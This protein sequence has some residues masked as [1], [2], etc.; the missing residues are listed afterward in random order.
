MRGAD[1]STGTEEEKWNALKSIVY[2]VFNDK[3]STAVRKHEVW[4]NRNRMELEEFMK[5]RNQ[6]RNNML[7]KFGKAGYRTC[8]KLP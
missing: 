8:Y 3:L 7:S 2:K 1:C 6:A 5:R 4:F